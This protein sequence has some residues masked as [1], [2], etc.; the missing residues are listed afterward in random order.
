MKL[1]NSGFLVFIVFVSCFRFGVDVYAADMKIT[2]YLPHF[3]AG[4]IP[5][6]EWVSNISIKNNGK[7]VAQIDLLAYG[8]NGQPLYLLTD[9]GYS[10]KFS[11]VIEGNGSLVLHVLRNQPFVIGWIK[12]ESIFPSSFSVYLEYKEFIPATDQVIGKASVFSSEARSVLTFDLKPENGVAIVNTGA[13]DS[14]VVFTAYNEV[15]VE[16]KNGSFLLPR[17]NQIA[18]FLNQSPFF[19]EGKGKVVF[20]SPISKVSG[21]ALDFDGF[22]FSTLPSL[23]TPRRISPNNQWEGAKIGFVYWYSDDRNP[24]PGVTDRIAEEIEVKQALFDKELPLNGFESKPLPFAK[25]QNGKPAILVVKGGNREKYI[26]RDKT[27]SYERWDSNLIRA[28]FMPF[29]PS[30]WK[31][32]TVFVDLWAIRNGQLEDFPMMGGG[33]TAWMT[34]AL[35]PFMKKS[36]FGNKNPYRGAPI[37]EFGNQPM[38][39]DLGTTFEDLAEGAFQTVNH[40]D[41][42]AFFN[43]DHSQVEE[44]FSRYVSMMGA[45]SQN[46]CFNSN[47]SVECVLL[48]IEA[49]GIAQSLIMNLDDYG[50]MVASPAPKI[51]VI[52]KELHGS[53]L[54]VVFRIVDHEKSGISSV[55]IQSTYVRPFAQYWREIGHMEDLNNLVIETDIFG[56][57][58][59]IYL[60]AI[61]NQGVASAISLF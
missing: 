37:P 34:A 57:T 6:S 25:D 1:K 50:Y 40:E 45:A 13:E 19:L 36:L 51:E 30:D 54:K 2:Q 18:A 21:I 39:G 5:A 3:V 7:S 9:R 58:R 49:V 14:F 4:S 56:T 20:I 60:S 28:D 22:T 35:L 43:L 31:F 32:L 11:L 46:G 59:D 15:G 41:G 53:R 10:N 38:F 33:G 17:G 26:H 48:P 29:V 52:S 47:R 42:H 23:P 61:N 44:R 55:S 8:Q 12:T 16:V 27:D 24:Q